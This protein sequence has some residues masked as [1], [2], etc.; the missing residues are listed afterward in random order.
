MNDTAVSPF[1]LLERAA[2]KPIAA[3]NRFWFAA[4]DPATLGLVRILAGAMLFYTHLVWTIDLLA[5]FGP[6]SW[7][8]LDAARLAHATPADMP[9]ELYG[10][11]SFVWSVF[12]VATTPEAV[13]AV[14]IT[15]LVVFALLTVGLF[16]R[17]AATLAWILAVS[18][19]YRTPGALF[20][21]D[22]IN[23]LLAFALMIGP[24]GACYSLDSW[25]RRRRAAAHS[26]PNPGYTRSVAANV[27]VRLIQLHMCVIYMF[28]G[29][30]K[31]VGVAWWNGTGLWGAVANYEYQSLDATWLAWWPVFGAIMSH[32]TVYWEVYY[33]VLIWPRATRPWM[34]LI[35]IPLH[36]GIALF[37]G[38]MTF[39]LVMLIANL[40]FVRPETTRA[41]LCWLFRRSPRS[42]REKNVAPRTRQRL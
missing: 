39:G 16:T 33:P 24:G 9:G 20:G 30:G 15:A 19:V 14:H 7:V 25:F 6:D 38:M 10:G 5:F 41:A 8:S 13:W 34:L 40:A 22:Q 29:F 31:L 27:A 26:S 32:V 4:V 1:E 42:A 18:Y 2:R 28:A 37:M 23:T 36:L 3:W 21:L 11:T 35:A 12:Y 17:V